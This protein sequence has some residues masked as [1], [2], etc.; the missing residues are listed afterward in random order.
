M[1]EAA[2]FEYEFEVPAA[3]VDANGH[4]NNVEFVRWMQDAAVRHADARGCTVATREAGAT[5]VVRAHRVEYKRPAFAGERVRVMTWVADFRR[6]FSRRR[7]RFARAA[8]GT[9]LADGE[10]DWAF[11]DATTG[12]PRSIPDDVQA[13]FELLPD[14]PV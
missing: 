2:V 11:V 3:A 1:A 4:A 6:A 7:Y 10:T 12:R 13:M 8:D 9:L 14:G 5:W